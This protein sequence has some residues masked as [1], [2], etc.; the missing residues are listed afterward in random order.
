MPPYNTP[1][2]IVSL[3]LV[4][5]ASR[6]SGDRSSPGTHHGPDWPTN[7][8]AG[9]GANRRAG[10]LLPSGAGSCQETQSCNKHELLHKHPPHDLDHDH[11]VNFAKA[12]HFAIQIGE[13]GTELESLEAWRSISLLLRCQ[14]CFVGRNAWNLRLCR[15]LTWVNKN[16]ERLACAAEL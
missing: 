16:Q 15:R 1:A 5:D 12:G 13:D 3:D 2:P 6:R 14:T 11:Q 4:H 10:A 7:H 8:R 9:R